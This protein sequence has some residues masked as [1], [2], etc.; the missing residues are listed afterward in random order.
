MKY[1]NFELFTNRNEEKFKKIHT[2][3]PYLIK[4][5]SVYHRCTLHEDNPTSEI[6]E[7]EDGC[8]VG[9]EKKKLRVLLNKPIYI[10]FKVL[11]I[12]KFVIY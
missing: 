2:R 4:Q 1:S 5:E 3:K 8:V 7:D 6:C 11:E 10:G 12:S 9:M